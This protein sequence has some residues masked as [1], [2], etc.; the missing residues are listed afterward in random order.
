M[1]RN[2]RSKEDRRTCG[3]VV[4]S[5]DSGSSAKGS[6]TMAKSGRD[7]W[8]SPMGVALFSTM[9]IICSAEVGAISPPVVRIP[10]DPRWD[11]M[12]SC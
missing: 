4:G 1:M 11:A 2:S 5:K 8:G 9:V 7:S 6:K 12:A 3:L 10:E